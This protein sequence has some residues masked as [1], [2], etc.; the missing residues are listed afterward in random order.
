M[1]ASE[2]CR[3]C[4]RTESG[5]TSS[6][7]DFENRSYFSAAGR[8][9]TVKEAGGNII[10]NSYETITDTAMMVIGHKGTHI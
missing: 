7:G 8:F 1:D 2:W 9:D 6:V 4:G 10:E 3:C 5:E